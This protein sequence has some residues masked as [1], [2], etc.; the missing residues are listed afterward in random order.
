[1]SDRREELEDVVSDLRDHDAVVDAFVA[2]SFTDR[3]VIVDID[4]AD[5]VP[6]DVVEHLADHDLRGA[7]GVYSDGE[8]QSFAGSVGDS[9]RHHFLDMQTR[10]AHQSYVVEVE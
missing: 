2:K 7:D 1:M 10:G 5:E 3:L 6:P 8:G 9:T 4:G